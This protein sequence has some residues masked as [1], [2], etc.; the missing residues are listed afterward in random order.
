MIYV[1]LALYFLSGVG[2]W[3]LGLR[4]EGGRKSYL[5]AIAENYDHPR[6]LFILSEIV[7]ILFWPFF[8]IRGIVRDNEE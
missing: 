5:M 2:V 4:A 7:V 6:L 1:L 3:E 8:I